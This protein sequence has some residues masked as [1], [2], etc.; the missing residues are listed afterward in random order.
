[1]LNRLIDIAVRYRAATLIASGLFAAFG[2][3]TLSHLKIEAF[4]DVT[5]VPVM[6]ISLYP[7]QAAEPGERVAVRG[8]S[9]S[10]APRGLEWGTGPS[11]ERAAASCAVTAGAPRRCTPATVPSATAASGSART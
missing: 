2:V 3:F 5:N 9:R 8:L 7:G 10:A 6:V 11:S 1:M 4:P